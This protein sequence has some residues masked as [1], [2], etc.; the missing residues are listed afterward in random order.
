MIIIDFKPQ[1][2]IKIVIFYD[3]IRQHK[4]KNRYKYRF[5]Y[6]LTK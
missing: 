3:F 6:F 2:M 4:Y 5:S 1:N